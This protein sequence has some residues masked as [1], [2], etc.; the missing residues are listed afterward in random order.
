MEAASLGVAL[1][2]GGEET[3]GGEEGTVVRTGLPGTTGSGLPP[4]SLPS[5]DT[6]CCRSLSFSCCCAACCCLSRSRCASCL[7][8]SAASCSM[9]SY[10]GVLHSAKLSGFS[11][12]TAQQA[13]GRNNSA[14]VL[15]PSTFA[16]RQHL[17]LHS[18]SS[19]KPLIHTC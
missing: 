15:L 6:A 19:N 12:F 14:H 16:P 4:A 10:S 7:L 5:S 1:P 13:L 11:G 2:L 9:C 18:A 8:L 3:G 17:I